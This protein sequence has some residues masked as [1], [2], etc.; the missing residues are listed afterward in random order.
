[1][2]FSQSSLK[3]GRVRVESRKANEGTMALSQGS[4]TPIKTKY[5]LTAK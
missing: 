2:F 5:M 3:K 1:M 4:L